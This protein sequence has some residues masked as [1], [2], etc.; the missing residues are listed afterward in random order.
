M[1]ET[2]D[3]IGLGNMGQPMTHLLHSLLVQK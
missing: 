1:N 3:F 2:I